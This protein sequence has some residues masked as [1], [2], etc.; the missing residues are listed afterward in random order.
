M[1]V[2]Y[3][4]KLFVCLFVEENEDAAVQAAF[5]AQRHYCTPLTAA[6]LGI[7]AAVLP[8]FGL[9]PGRTLDRLA[10]WGQNFL[11]GV[12]PAHAVHYFSFENLKGG[13]ISIL[14]GAI[15]YAL[16]RRFLMGTDNRGQQVYVNRWPQ[17]LDLL[18]LVYEPLLLHILPGICGFVCRVLDFLPDGLILLLRTTTHRQL[19][20]SGPPPTGYLLSYYPGR[21]V[22]RVVRLLNATV[23]KRRPHREDY[24]RR[25]AERESVFKAS[26]RMIMASTSFSLLMFGVGMVI[27]VL[28]M[29]FA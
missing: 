26:H 17:R 27:A 28:Y 23:W 7:S 10:D 25:F 9:L 4:T 22:N 19:A 3:M 6:V 14:L 8:L 1:T 5:D 11:K 29:L 20:E 21:L 2:A 13:L 16:N 18:T 24:V 12:S 15:L